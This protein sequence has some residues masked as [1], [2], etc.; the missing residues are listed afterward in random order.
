MNS[1]V[2]AGRITKDLELNKTQSNKSYV[3]FTLAVKRM[4]DEVDFINCIAWEN[5]AENLVKFMSKGSQIGVEGR[6]Q[7]GSYETDNGTRYTT[8]VVAVRVHFLES[9]KENNNQEQSQYHA[10]NVVGDE[11][12]PF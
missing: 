10:Q 6:I 2:I 5:Q 11:T 4:G 1:V 9:K 7:T 3:R 12:L 8:D